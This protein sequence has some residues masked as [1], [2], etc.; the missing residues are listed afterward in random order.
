MNGYRKHFDHLGQLRAGDYNTWSTTDKLI[1]VCLAV[2][3][4]L[5]MGVYETFH[6]RWLHRGYARIFSRFLLVEKQS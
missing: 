3:I 1:V 6:D 4:L 2:T 5:L